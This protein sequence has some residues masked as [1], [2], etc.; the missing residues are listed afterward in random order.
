M[1]KKAQVAWNFASDELSMF[2]QDDA[3]RSR[4]AP[5]L[6]T[7]HWHEGFADRSWSPV[8]H[9][10][11][12][13]EVMACMEAQSVDLV[14]CDPP[15]GTTQNVWDAVIPLAEMWQQ[16]W[17][18]C[19]G[20][21]VMTS[22]QP[23]SSAL[24]MSQP[25]FFR[26]E[27]VW[28]KNKATG[29]LNAKKAPMRAHELVLVFSRKAPRYNPQMTEGHRPMN[30]YVQTSNGANYGSTIRPAGGGATVRYP[31]SVQQFP[32]IN[33]DDPTKVHPTQKPEA[34]M[35]YLVRTYSFEGA[36]VLDF[37]MGS[38]T[39]GAACRSTGRHFV[40]IESDASYFE[41]AERRL[42]PTT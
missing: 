27:W 28:E 14:L 23:F 2:E 15:Y 9:H 25:Q 12:C 5:E 18:V 20:P 6:L 34:L 7:R 31:R 17:R 33:N 26:H 13:L 39:T 36:T 3:E 41:T 11:D 16:L 1:P 8:L 30:S 21:V 42:I 29:H 35:E 40:G 32:I 22:M 24:V 38:G 10:G 19:R 4:N 37:A